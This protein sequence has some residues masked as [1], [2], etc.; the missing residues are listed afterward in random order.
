MAADWDNDWD[1]EEY[2]KRQSAA[3]LYRAYNSALANGKDAARIKAIIVAKSQETLESA[4]KDDQLEV[5]PYDLLAFVKVAEANDLQVQRPDGSAWDVKDTIAQKINIQ[6]NALSGKDDLISRLKRKALLESA[7]IVY[8]DDKDAV[9][10]LN[11]AIQQSADE[12][13]TQLTSAQDITDEEFNHFDEAEKVGALDDISQDAKDAFVA[14]LAELSGWIIANDKKLNEWVYSVRNNEQDGSADFLYS[15]DIYDRE[16]NLNPLYDMCQELA[17]KLQFSLPEGLSADDPQAQAL[18]EASVNQLLAASAQR[19]TNKFLTNRDLLNQYRDQKSLLNGFKAEIYRNFER[20]VVTAGLLGSTETEILLKNIKYKDGKWSYDGGDDNMDKAIQAALDGKVTIHPLDLDIDKR[21]LDLETKK[22]ERLL[23]IRKIRKDEVPFYT[24]AITTGKNVWNSLIKQGGW[25]KAVANAGIFGLSAVATA[26]SATAVIA[27]GAAVYAGWTAVNAWVMPV[28]DKISAE[29]R[30][31]GITGLKNRIAYLRS[32][33]KDVKKATYAEKDFKK[34]AALRTAEGL[35]AGGIMATFG[36]GGNAGGWGKTL[37]RQFTSLFGKGATFFTSLAAK[38]PLA[39]KSKE[40][41]VS[42]TQEQQ[43]QAAE[44]RV[45][46]DGITVLAVATGAVAGDAVKV[47]HEIR[48]GGNLMDGYDLGGNSNGHAPTDSLSHAPTD[49]LS[50]R[51]S[52]LRGTENQPGRGVLLDSQNDTTTSHAPVDSLDRTPADSLSTPADSLDHTPTTGDMPLDGTTPVVDATSE[53]TFDA[54]KLSQDEA[55]MYLNSANKWDNNALANR[56]AELEKEGHSISDNVRQSLEETYKDHAFGKSLVENFYATIESGKVETLPEGMSAVEYVDKLTRLSQL[57]PYAQRQAIE[58][59]TKDLLCEDFTPTAE[60][61]DLVKGALNTIVYD[62]NASMDCVIPDVNGNLCIKNVSMFG[63]YVGPQQT[64]EVQ[65]P[66]GTMQ[67]LPLRNANITTGLSATVDCQEGSAT[68]ISTYE[69]HTLADCGCV[70]KEAEP[71]IEEPVVR[72]EP[73]PEGKAAPTITLEAEG[74][75]LARETVGIN[76]KSPLEGAKATATYANADYAVT[77]QTSDNA[78]YLRVDN[79]GYAHLWEPDGTQLA[80]I[81]V[82]TQTDGVE[83]LRPVALHIEGFEKLGTPEISQDGDTVSFSYGEGRNAPRVELNQATGDASF[84][85]GKREY[86]LDQESAQGLAEKMSNDWSQSGV[87]QRTEL[88]STP[89]A[90]NS[91]DHLTKVGGEEFEQDA[92]RLSDKVEDKISKYMNNNPQA[93]VED[94]AT[95]VA[96]PQA[97][98]VTHAAEETAAPAAEPKAEEVITPVEEPQTPTEDANSNPQTSEAQSTDDASNVVENNY[99]ISGTTYDSSTGEY[100]FVDSRLGK[101]TYKFDENGLTFSSTRGYIPDQQSFKKE[102]ILNLYSFEQGVITDIS[103]A[104]YHGTT[105]MA[106]RFL[107]RRL[108]N[109]CA[110]DSVYYHLMGRQ[111]AGE[112]LGAAEQQ[113]I[114]NHAAKLGQYGY[115]HDENGLLIPKPLDQVLDQ[116]YDVV[117]QNMVESLDIQTADNVQN[118]STSSINGQYAISPDGQ[119]S[120]NAKVDVLNSDQLER[121]FSHKVCAI[122]KNEDGSFS[123]VTGN[124]HDKDLGDVCRATD[125]IL[126]GLVKKELV[127]QDLKS[128]QAGG[129]N[130]GQ[131]ETTFMRE[132]NKTLNTYGLQHNREGNLVEFKGNNMPMPRARGGRG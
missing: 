37:G 43:L 131:G 26:S 106:M 6:E 123:D 47:F 73:L 46:Q 54:S 61:I 119:L 18:R 50:H 103:G 63:Q 130:L 96:E 110:Q 78:L 121:T 25:K 80:D 132:Y 22:V 71:I 105:E 66:D 4:A 74:A 52:V 75:G 55:R 13:S 91:N 120:M 1:D 112:T 15:L 40:G 125:K 29:M 10:T 7:R 127:Y 69:K 9:E 68:I 51:F 34:R 19:A 65:M 93:P 57:A 117:K 100:T 108:N 101:L 60:Q 64:V 87:D 111:E 95:P 12:I 67:E 72:A 8:K 32:R 104:E 41:S 77:N 113:F 53:Y 84:F 59:M 56:I 102:V 81:N 33:W 86:I 124:I 49:S 99:D 2:L 38:N 89:E 70:R 126:D 23:K 79:K 109:L 28:Y 27:A 85:V 88:T 82:F 31:K 30:Q 92:A 16:G 122:V 44:K 76:F 24:K 83:T 39:K 36:L 48:I 98:E 17:S 129:E 21:Q 35:V 62:K 42:R 58:I 20:S 3:T 128:R 118:I 116:G 90:E 11:Q 5:N 107:E 94:A 115:T 114:T 45:K 14:R 97:E